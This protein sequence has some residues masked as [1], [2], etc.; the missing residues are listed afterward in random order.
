MPGL[1]RREFVAAL[2][3]VAAAAMAPRVYAA[4]ARPISIALAAR[5]PQTLN[6]SR[7]TLGADNWACRQIFDTLVVPQ[8]GTFA[9]TPAEFKPGIAERWESSPDAKIWTFYIRKGVPFH[10]GYGTVTSD[11][12]VFTFGRLIDPNVVVSGK[13]L[14]ENIG[15]VAALD[16]STV[17]F[18]L[19]KPDPIF[20]GSSIY[21]MSGN[22][23]SRKAFE[24]SGDKFAFDPIGTGP[25]QFD[26]VDF[27]KGVYLKAFPEHFRGPPASPEL[28]I[29]YILDT[30]ARTLAFLSGQVDMI[31]GARTPGWMQSIQQRKRD[32]MFDATKPGSFNSL[33][34]NLTRKP[35]DN[36]KVRQAVR[37]AINRDALAEA[38]GPMGG[39]TWGLIPPEFPGSV[40]DKTLSPELQYKFNPAKAKQLLAEAGYPNGVAFSCF[41][42]QREDYSAIMLMVQEQLRDVGFKMDMQIIDHTTFH[43]QSDR[44]L[45]SFIMLSSSYPPVP[46]QPLLEQLS[47]HAVV[48]PDGSGGANYGHY[49][50]AMPGVDGLL[51]Q[52]L[53]EPDFAKRAALCQQVEIQ[54]L[55]DLP[56]IGLVTLSYVIAR[57][58]DVSLGYPVKSGYAYWP[59]SPAHPVA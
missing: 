45:N 49:G 22:I 33:H 4:S 44:D 5:S 25:F 38:Y 41:T 27:A 37:Y 30:T 24:E 36:L 11:D 39:V 46:T 32:T 8:D 15:K 34:M 19:K 9:L 53:N 18:T 26:R 42:S 14:Y 35:F 55:R 12:V 21:T 51:E 56:V 17:Q 7:T 28:D 50:I 2:S 43:S 40:T 3:G 6:P 59:L 47:S 29:F 54:V 20:C 31:E 13:V 16:P 1:L 10:K 48:K 23:L 57:N 52:V 58:P